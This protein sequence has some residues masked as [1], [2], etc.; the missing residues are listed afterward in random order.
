[1]GRDNIREPT[2]EG[3]VD[4][5]FPFEAAMYRERERARATNNTR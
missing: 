5:L 3:I 1:M 2:S 4:V